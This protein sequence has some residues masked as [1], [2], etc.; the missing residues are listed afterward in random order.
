MIDILD[1]DLE[2]VETSARAARG[3]AGDQY[4]LELVARARACADSPH[5]RALLARI[6]VILPLVSRT[7]AV[8]MTGGRRVVLAAADYPSIEDDLIE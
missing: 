6:A 5:R 2:A 1:I 3:G 4:L 8:P 7:V